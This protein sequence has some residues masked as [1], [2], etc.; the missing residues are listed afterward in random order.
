MCFPMDDTEALIKN[1]QNGDKDA[2]GKLYK[3]YYTRIYRYCRLNLYNAPVADDACQEVFIRAW[4]ALP[5]FTLKDGGT[6]QAFL[7][8]IARNLI[9]DLSRKKKEISIEAIGEISKEE[10][11]IEGI[12]QKEDIQ[13]VRNAMAKLPDVDRQIIILRYFE[14]MSHSDIAKIINIKEGALRVRTIRLL[15]KLKEL[16]EP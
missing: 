11:L 1:A 15:K 4:K 9:I 14:E 8:R 6:F 5:K 3:Q 12:A 2:Y 10:N 13:R 7:F 16:I